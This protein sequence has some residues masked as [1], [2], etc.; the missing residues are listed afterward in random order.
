MAKTLKTK[1]LVAGGSLDC[2]IAAIRA[3]QLDLE[4]ALL[5]RDRVSGTCLPSSCMRWRQWCG[6]SEVTP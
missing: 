4:T 3:G 2:C 5:E 1:V 6:T